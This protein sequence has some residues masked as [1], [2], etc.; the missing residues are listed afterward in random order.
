MITFSQLGQ[1]G[2]LGNQLFEVA[3]TVGLA[4]RVKESYGFPEWEYSKHCN[5][6]NCYYDNLK[7]TNIYH[8]PF[9]HYKKIDNKNNNLDL[10]G[11]FQSYKYF[12]DY[13]YFILDAL[14][15]NLNLN[16]E[17]DLCGI[18]VRKGDYINLKDCYQQLDMNYYNQAIEEIKSDRY[19]IF[20]DDI[21][22]CKKNFIGDKFQFSQGR[23]PHED[24]AIMAKQCDNMIIANS[25]FS[26]WGAYLNTNFN[27]KIIAPKKWFGPKLPHDTSDLLPKEWIV[28]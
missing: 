24:L 5:L 19:I 17:S 15:P 14:V 13:K 12:D 18:H 1:W 9:F 21:E 7:I 26:W 3:T 11:Y 28:I 8:E 4:L 22:W 16:P 2:R 27:K 20:S 23:E 10:R 25:S 6:Q